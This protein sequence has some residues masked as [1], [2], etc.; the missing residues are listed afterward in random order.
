MVSSR[1]LTQK[2]RITLIS[3]VIILTVAVDLATKQWARQNLNGH[4]FR[5]FDDLLVFEHSENPGAFLSLG[6]AMSPEFRFW[7]FTIG[8]AAILVA[9]LIYLFKNTNLPRA[10]TVA[11]AWIV[12]G[13]I[14][15]LVD[16][17]QKQTVTDFIN[18]GIGSLRTGIFNIADMAITG[19]VLILVFLPF[20]GAKE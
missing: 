8:I 20:K 5:Y 17:I 6:S 14:G 10:Q 2:K 18:M 19:A 11:Y 4:I 12:A 7:I 9:V 3:F 16:R 1:N 13:G 15:N